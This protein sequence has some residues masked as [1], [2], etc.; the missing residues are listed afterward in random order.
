MDFPALISLTE[1][2][3]PISEKLSHFLI[4][5]MAFL[6]SFVFVPKVKATSAKS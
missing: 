3:N 4:V 1:Q 6:I 5:A 2:D